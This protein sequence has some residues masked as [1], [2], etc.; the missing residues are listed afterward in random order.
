[1]NGLKTFSAPLVCT[2]IAATGEIIIVVLWG[3]EVTAS[4][5]FIS[6]P[7]CLPLTCTGCGNSSTEPTHPGSQKTLVSIFFFILNIL[8]YSELS[9]THKGR[10]VS[11]IWRGAHFRNRIFPGRK[12]SSVQSPW[13]A[14]IIPG[15]CAELMERDG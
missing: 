5:G 12:R 10:S 2:A 4:Q 15:V 1:M 6:V 11:R 8:F 9:P 14:G 7:G 13:D 3:G